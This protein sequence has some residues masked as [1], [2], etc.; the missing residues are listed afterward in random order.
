MQSIYWCSY[1]HVSVCEGWQEESW[2]SRRCSRP[3]AG[4]VHDSSV[5][6]RSS[7]VI[8]WR[9]LQSGRRDAQQGPPTTTARL[10]NCRG[11]ALPDTLCPAIDN[12]AVVSL[13]FQLMYRWRCPSV[14]LSVT[15]RCHVKTNTHSIMRFHHLVAG[16]R[17][18]SF[19]RPTFI[20]WLTR[21]TPGEGCKRHCGR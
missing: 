17:V 10:A 2:P 14:R 7:Q 12:H 16:P 18:C 21:N 1:R 6:S 13:S 4:R 9:W 3:A 20:A 5:V 19:L 8:R 11:P 15:S